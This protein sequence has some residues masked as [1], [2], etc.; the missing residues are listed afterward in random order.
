MPQAA[1]IAQAAAPKLGQGF[2]APQVASAAPLKRTGP[3]RPR[4]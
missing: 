2:N 4:R 1:Q 3:L